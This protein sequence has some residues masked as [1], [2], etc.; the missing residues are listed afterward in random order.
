MNLTGLLH[1]NIN[2]SDFDRSKVFYERLGFREL[3][4]IE[5]EA[6]G[7]IAAAVGVAEYRLRGALMRSR[8]GTII[9]LLEWQN[10]RD[11]ERPYA[12]LN[13]LGLARMAFISTDIDADMETLRAADVTFVSEEPAVVTT[14]DGSV[15]RFICFED[16][17]GTVL[18]LVE[19]TPPPKD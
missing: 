4:P 9:D 10:P 13:H 6:S 17:D 18:E 19:M 16:P 8:D 1:V 12:S 11:V 3:M 14:P 5:Q 7:A 2:C 15:S